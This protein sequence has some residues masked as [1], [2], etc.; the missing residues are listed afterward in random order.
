M[1]NNNSRLFRGDYCKTPVNNDYLVGFFTKLRDALN[2]AGIRAQEKHIL[3]ANP[4]EFKKHNWPSDTQQEQ[5]IRR[6]VSRGT[7]LDD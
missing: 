4:E 5:P 2:D 7:Y 1:N 3:P 6:P